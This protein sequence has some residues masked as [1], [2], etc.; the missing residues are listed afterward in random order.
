MDRQSDPDYLH[1]L[2]TAVLVLTPQLQ[3]RYANHAAE[4]LL[5]LGQRRLL[6]QNAASLYSQLAT[7]TALLRQTLEREQGQSLYA[8]S[9]VTLDG[10]HHTIDLIFTPLESAEILVEARV[11]DHQQRISQELQHYAQQHAAQLLVRGLAHEIKNPLGGL[12]GA[13]QLLER[14]LDD[15]ELKEFTTIIIEQ[16]DRLRGLVDR[17]LGPQYPGTWAEGNVHRLLEQVARLCEMEAT[18]TLVIERDYDPSIP[19]FVMDAEQLQQALL[20]VVRNA[21]QALDGQGRIVLRTRSQGQTTIAGRRHRQVVAVS[22]VD[23]GP[24][25]D[26]S[27]QDTLFYP[28]V[29]NKADGS[30]LGL[31]IAQKIVS[32]HQGRIELESWPGHTEFTLLLP[33]T[34]SKEAQ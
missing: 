4:Q 29:T 2:S 16:S 28:M 21:V 9:L 7:D 17:L 11:V 32:Q 14:E 22:V 10:Q 25:I 1:Q 33:M 12:R 8:V 31:S 26:P 15:P 27:I 23:D 6:G 3:V 19:D 30:G 20:N 13:A 5:G 34:F 18:G 24:G